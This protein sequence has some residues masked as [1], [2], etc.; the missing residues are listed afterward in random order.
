MTIFSAV[1]A[2]TPTTVTIFGASYVLVETDAPQVYD[3]TSI[4]LTPDVAGTLNR[5]G[6]QTRFTLVP[7]EMLDTQL[8]RYRS[9]LY[10]GVV[11]D[12]Y[13]ADTISDQLFE[14]MQR[15]EGA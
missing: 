1:P 2:A 9:G 13:S 12:L 11:S 3:Y 7:T 6:N 15:M 5:G 8:A 10:V 4:A 14:R